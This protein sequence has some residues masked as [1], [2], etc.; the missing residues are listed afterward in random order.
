MQVKNS[1]A[2]SINFIFVWRRRLGLHLGLP[3]A[4]LN[5]SSGVLGAKSS[6]SQKKGHQSE[7][8]LCGSIVLSPHVLQV[9]LVLDP[10][11]Q[12]F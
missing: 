3:Q 9:I 10:I 8:K 4:Y 2:V 5:V 12:Y 1:L 6:S 7:L 11:L